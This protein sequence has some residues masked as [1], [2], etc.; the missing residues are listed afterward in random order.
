MQKSSNPYIKVIGFTQKKVHITIVITHAKS[1]AAAYGTDPC[2]GAD[3][4]DG[5]DRHP[6]AAL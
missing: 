6:I 2:A 3:I 4:A 5:A 1:R